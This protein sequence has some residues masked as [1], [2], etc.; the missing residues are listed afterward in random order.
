MGTGQDLTCARVAD[1]VY[2]WGH[3]NPG[4]VGIGLPA[5]NTDGCINHCKLTPVAVLTAEDEPLTGVVDLNVGNGTVCAKR[6][7]DSLWCWGGNPQT[8]SYAAPLQINA[9][10]LTGVF[11]FTMCGTGTATNQLRY[12][13]VDNQLFRANTELQHSCP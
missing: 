7:D 6:S 9:A 10:P 8:D 1:R 2:C 11:D 13:N 3:N 4:Q 5:A 12:L